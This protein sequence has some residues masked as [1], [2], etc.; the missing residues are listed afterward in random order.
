MKLVICDDDLKISQR[1]EELL[2]SYDPKLFDI[3]VFN[4]PKRFLKTLESSPEK[5]YDFYFLDIEMPHLTGIDLADAV[6]KVD[7]FAPIIFLTSYEQYM[8]DVF[9][10]QTFDYLLKPPTKEKIYPVLDRIVL[11]LTLNEKKFNFEFNRNSYSVPFNEI[12]FF[13]KDKRKVLIETIHGE[14]MVTMTTS[15]LLASLQDDFVQIHASYIVNCRYIKKINSQSV[16]L[17]FQGTEREL[18]ISRR[19]QQEARLKIVRQMRD[20]V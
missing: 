10:L 19:F 16:A 18:P 17:N 15:E 14:Y 13:E 2:L 8:P 12:V 1:I 7:A 20:L 4:D 11:Y 5:K 3:D 9:R 6:R